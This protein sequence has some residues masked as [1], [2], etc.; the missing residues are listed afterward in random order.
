[1][2]FYYDKHPNLI[3]PIMKTTVCK[4]IKQPQINNTISDKISSY[5]SDFY[6]EYIT[7]NKALVIL[8]LVFIGFL[9]YR[10]Y[11]KKES[12]KT[13]KIENIKENFVDP[14]SQRDSNLLKELE[15]YQ[16]QHLEFDN[17]P[18]MN[19]LYP[20][21]DQNQNDIIHYPPDKLPIRLN[22]DE[23]LV[24]RRNIYPNPPPFTQLNSPGNYDYNNVY[25]NEDRNYYSGTYDTYVNAQN[26]PIQNPFNWS[27]EFNTNTGNF[28]SPMTQRNMQNLKE[29]QAQ[30]DT[31]KQNLM[32][33]LQFGRQYTVGLVDPPFAN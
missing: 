19:P 27:N 16:T 15:K 5:L 14:I 26:T 1:M 12:F 18:S 25:T 20:P 13:E 7:N 3:G 22:P 9:I 8:I 30:Q 29:Y 24:M 31:E 2:E 11:N 33:S 17:P 32:N 28:V 6:N 23:G 21:K 10:Y 4:I